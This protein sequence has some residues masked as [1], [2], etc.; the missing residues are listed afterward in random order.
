MV[1]VVGSGRN[2][3]TRRVCLGKPKWAWA[4]GVASIINT[5]V[6]ERAES[7]LR[8][9]KRSARNIL[10]NLETILNATRTRYSWREVA[11]LNC[12]F[13]HL[14]VIYS[15]CFLC[16]SDYRFFFPTWLQLYSR[17]I[18]AVLDKNIK[19]IYFSFFMYRFLYIFPRQ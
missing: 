1:P 6:R 8:C 14:E 16:I 19:R 10:W 2:I 13:R 15:R 9:A 11:F 7:N 12:V 5:C 4:C 3:V 17:T 18:F